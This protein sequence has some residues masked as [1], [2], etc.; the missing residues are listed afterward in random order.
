MASAAMPKQRNFP[1]RGTRCWGSPRR[2]SSASVSATAPMAAQARGACISRRREVTSRLDPTTQ[3]E[4]TLWS[5][6]DEE[7]DEDEHHDLA[8]HRAGRGLDQLVDD[9]QAQRG[10]D[11]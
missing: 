7:D 2:G 11:S 4:Q 1:N 8:Q 3:R 6:L 5:A 10:G 9:S